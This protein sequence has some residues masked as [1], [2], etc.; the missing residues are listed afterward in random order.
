MKIV[1][2]SDM[3]NIL[4]RSD[5]LSRSICDISI[6]YATDLEALEAKIPALME[7]IRESVCRACRDDA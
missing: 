7:R 5:N 2:N 6:P 4:N 1:N 3:K